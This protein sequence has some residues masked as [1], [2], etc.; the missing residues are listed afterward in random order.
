MQGASARTEAQQ[1][2]KQETRCRDIEDSDKGIKTLHQKTP[3]IDLQTHPGAPITADEEQ[4][5]IHVDE[6]HPAATFPLILESGSEVATTSK[7]HQEAFERV[8]RLE[9]L[10]ILDLTEALQSDIESESI[11]NLTGKTNMA[12]Y[13]GD[14][15]DGE[16]EVE[17]P[18]K[19]VATAT[20]TTSHPSEEQ[21]AIEV[22]VDK[23]QQSR[24][25]EEDQ[26]VVHAAEDNT[27]PQEGNEVV[28]KQAP[29]SEDDKEMK[30]LDMSGIEVKLKEQNCEEHTYLSENKESPVQERPVKSL[31]IENQ[32]IEQEQQN[33]EV[34]TAEDDKTVQPERIKTACEQA[35][36]AEQIQELGE[37]NL[38]DVE[39]EPNEEACQHETP[40]VQIGSLEQETTES[41]SETAQATEEKSEAQQQHEAVCLQ[42]ASDR[43]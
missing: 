22:P 24:E 13:E 6:E 4:A 23:R 26:E 32:H 41:G 1:G 29:D 21:D 30:E 17:F 5:S 38:C 16:Q 18:R 28:C 11:K 8:F 12:P 7:A 42:E 3:G 37:L 33:K 40:R 35:S 20:A 9:Q 15:R 43:I 19:E 14:S 36:F 31:E 27:P 34:V 39:I 10:C 2:E 25:E